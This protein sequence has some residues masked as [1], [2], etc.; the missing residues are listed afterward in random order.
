MII[1]QRYLTGFA[2]SGPPNRLGL[3]RWVEYGS[4]NKVP[5]FNLTFIDTQDD[6]ETANERCVVRVVAEGALWDYY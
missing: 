1:F 5:N 3:A 6:M 4:S 2:E